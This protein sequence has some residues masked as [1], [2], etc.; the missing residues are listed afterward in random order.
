MNRLLNE[1][2]ISHTLGLLK[3]RLFG[4]YLQAIQLFYILYK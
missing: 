4:A 2:K 1:K 3:G